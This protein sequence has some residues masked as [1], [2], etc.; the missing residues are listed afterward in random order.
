MKTIVTIAAAAIIAL[1][2]VG[3]AWGANLATN[4]TKPETRCGWFSN[5]TPGNAWLTDGDAEWMIGVQGGYQAEG[6]WPNFKPSQWRKT[7]VNYGYGCACMKVTTNRSENQILRIHSAY[8]KP[9]SACRKDPKL[10]G[11]EYMGS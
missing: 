7:N 2:V 5:P 1:P 4:L 9:L 8:A 11:T 10:K 6:D 3:F